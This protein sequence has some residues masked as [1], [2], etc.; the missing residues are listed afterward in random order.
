MPAD[1]RCARLAANGGSPER[2]PQL[3]LASLGAAG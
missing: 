1:V 2:Q 3:A